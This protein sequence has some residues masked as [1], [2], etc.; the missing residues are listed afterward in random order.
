MQPELTRDPLYFQVNDRLRAL[1]RGGTFRAGEQFLTERQVSERF[2]ISR[3]TANKALASLVGEGLLE[4]RKGIGTFV[5][6]GLLD[7]DLRTLVSFTE[8][9][10]VAGLIPTTEVRTFR[11]L[12]GNDLLEPI[13]TALAVS[14]ESV[15]YMER[16]R[17]ADAVPVI[18]ESRYLRAKYCAD[19][20]ANDL[21]GSFYRLLTEQY[22]L[23]IAGADEIIRAVS[24]SPEE[25]EIL[26]TV[27]GEAALGV[28]A[29]GNLAGGIPLWWERTLYR[30]EA[31]EFHNRLGP[32]TPATAMPAIGTLRDPSRDSNNPRK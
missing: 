25:A 4:F 20:R 16:L 31:Y 22:H 24:L 10:I 14:D 27:P 28:I 23:P 18:W 5:R 3:V 1:V 30:G 32:I 26:Q 7:Y 6:A 21:T 2:G 29:V 17:L 11:V 15:I 9:A 12:P 13:R 8:K 19:L